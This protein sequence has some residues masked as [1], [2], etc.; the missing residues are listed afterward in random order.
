MPALLLWPRRGSFSRARRARMMLP[1]AAT[2]IRCS[3]SAHVVAAVAGTPRA[4]R[5]GVYCTDNQA[6][7]QEAAHALGCLACART[8]PGLCMVWVGAR[9]VRG[10]GPCRE[11]VAALQ[12]RPDFVANL[13]I[14]ETLET[15]QNGRREHC[16]REALLA[17]R[18][19]IQQGYPCRSI[20]ARYDGACST[21][22]VWRGDTPGDQGVPGQGCSLGGAAGERG[23]AFRDH[24][25]GVASSS[26]KRLRQVQPN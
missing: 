18:S 6:A 24:G 14:R 4:L 1:M 8:V 3:F 5:V 7:S 15:C 17:V 25:A 21:A 22:L 2:A 23:G 9:G 12:R 19:R 11:T 16:N 20:P 10:T 13:T 26:W